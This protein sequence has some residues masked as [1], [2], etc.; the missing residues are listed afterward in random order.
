MNNTQTLTT[1]SSK[2]ESA[3]KWLQ[4]QL[5]K[6]A[7]RQHLKSSAKEESTQDQAVSMRPRTAPSSN[8]ERVTTAASFQRYSSHNDETTVLS[9]SPSPRPARPDPSVLRDVNA[10]LDASVT[11]DSP[12]LMDGLPYWRVAQAPGLRD[13]PYMQHAIPLPHAQNMVKPLTPPSQQT[14]SFR[15]HAKLMQRSVPFRIR[16]NCFEGQKKIHRA[17]ASMPLLSATCDHD[18]DHDQDSFSFELMPS[19]QCNSFLHSTMRTTTIPRSHEDEGCL[20]REASPEYHFFRSDSP[21]VTTTENTSMNIKR[22]VKNLFIRSGESVQ[23]MSSPTTAAGM[24]RETSVGEGS[25]A[26]TYF[27]GFSPPSYRSHTASILTTSS[28]GCIDG[29]DSA[30]REMSRQRAARQRGL[31]GKLKDFAR[32]FSR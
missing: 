16:G 10:W 23:R 24:H 27:S 29:M 5:R 17:S 19:D 20:V 8:T 3:R 28:F 15:R 9:L 13:S 18:H 4:R 12:A 11:K 2:P 1:P 22:S 6:T 31:R 26:P 32:T 21:V 30:Q 14:T 25:E 7:S